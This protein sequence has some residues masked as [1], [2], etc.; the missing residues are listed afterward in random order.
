MWARQKQQDRVHLE[1][2]LHII[3]IPNIIQE[4]DGGWKDNGEKSPLKVLKTEQNP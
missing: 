2:T 1:V 3:L 4:S